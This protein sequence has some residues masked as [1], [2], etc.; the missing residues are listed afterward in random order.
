MQSAYPMPALGNHAPSHKPE[1]QSRPDCAHRRLWASWRSFDVR[2]SAYGSSRFLIII[3]AGFRLR[4]LL[5]II[6]NDL[7]PALWRGPKADRMIRRSLGLGAR[8]LTHVASPGSTSDQINHGRSRIQRIPGLG[9]LHDRVA[10]PLIGK[11]TEIHPRRELAMNLISSIAQ[12]L[13]QQEGSA[14]S[15]LI[16]LSAADL[17]AVLDA[18]GDR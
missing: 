10:R 1:G 11:R 8:P 14:L 2:F 6:R 9:Q 13:Q 5:I 7:H 12:E 17:R 3:T 18:V 4:R 15:R 16:H